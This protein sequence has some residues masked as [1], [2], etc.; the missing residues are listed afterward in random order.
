[1]NQAKLGTMVNGSNCYSSKVVVNDPNLVQQK[2][3][4]IRLAGPS[5]FQV[6]FFSLNQLLFGLFFGT[7][8]VIVFLGCV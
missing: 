1:M 3:T 2:K 6:I 4:A 7:I 5:K 8:V